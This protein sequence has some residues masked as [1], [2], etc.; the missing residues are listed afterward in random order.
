MKK[1]N[2]P[3]LILLFLLFLLGTSLQWAM[4]NFGNVT[5]EQMLFL[6]QVPTEGVSS[7]LVADY[8]HKALLPSFLFWLLIV[9]LSVFPRHSA[10]GLEIKKNPTGTAD[11][12]IRLQ[13]LP[14]RIPASAFYFL[15]LCGFLSVFLKADSTFSVSEYVGRQ[16]QTSSLIEEEYIS[17][18][19]VSISFPE[20]K[21]NLICIY[22][23]SAETSA[24]DTASGGLMP[25]NYMPELTE[26]ARENTSFSSSALIEGAACAPGCGWTIAGLVA[27]T[28]GVPLMIPT[29]YRNSMNITDNF[30]P[31]VV[32]LGEI[33]EK[34]GYHNYF[35][36]GSDFTF[37]GR[38][39]YF[40]QHGNYQVFDHPWAAAGHLIPQDYKVWWGFED[41]KLFSFA[42]EKLTEIAARNEPFQFSLLT[43][44]THTPNGYVCRLCPDR[45]PGQYANVWSCASSQIASFV[46]WIQEQ[47]F[48]ENTTIV[49]S[50]DHLSMC[51]T[52]Y[53][54]QTEDDY[55]GQARRKVYNAFINPAVQADET[56][57]KNRR[58]TTMDM[59]PTVLASLGARIEGERLGLGTNL[60]S[61]IPT[62]SEKLG[63]P[64]L[65]TELQKKSRFYERTL[66][67]E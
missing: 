13:F 49:L 48:Y 54:T 58:F 46:H 67:Y 12:G 26:L 19:E 29:R 18:A 51:P 27:Q 44:D 61:G 62:L 37:G 42:R 57:E 63:Y 35:M 25:V 39:Q 24:Q 55:T 60:F 56:A 33:L 52:F 45:W 47:D 15:L 23:E 8:L 9:V 53:G 36:A 11:T 20:E 7:G 16:L 22:I 10:L 2:I 59:F 43:V 4:E 3:A 31:G 50:G 21:R 30:L 34:E 66:F 41:E 38:R 14:L 28:A 65:F 32:S 64:E 5:L 40:T 17:P 1:K 6:V